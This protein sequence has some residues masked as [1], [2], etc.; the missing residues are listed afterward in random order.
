MAKG[1]KP[2]KQEKGRSARRAA[3]RTKY[4]GQW[5]APGDEIEFESAAD[6]KLFDA[7]GALEPK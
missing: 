7:A 1:E 2:A 3:T 4:R 5:F 6:E